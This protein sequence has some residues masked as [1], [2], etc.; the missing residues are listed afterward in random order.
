MGSP[1]RAREPEHVSANTAIYRQTTAVTHLIG[2]PVIDILPGSFDVIEANWK[3]LS[4]RSVP[5][6]VT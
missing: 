2:D 5:A 1:S 6:F 3:D 4:S